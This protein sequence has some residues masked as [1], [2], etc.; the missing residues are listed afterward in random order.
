MSKLVK[1][2]DE[3]REGQY[4]YVHAVSGPGKLNISVKGYPI[5][6]K[7]FSRYGRKNVW[8]CYVRVGKSRLS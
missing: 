8:I 6:Q 4:G 5:H 3:E 7:N 1:I 2:G